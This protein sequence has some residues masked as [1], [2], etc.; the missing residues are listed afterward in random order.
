MRSNSHNPFAGGTVVAPQ[1]D[2]AEPPRPVPVRVVAWVDRYPPWQNA[3]G[4]WMLHYMLRHL[5]EVGHEVDVVTN[6]PAEFGGDLPHM[7]EGVRVWPHADRDRRTRILDRGDVLVG[8]LLW[9][10]K[11]VHE[12]G[13]RQIPLVYLFHNTMTIGSWNLVPVNVTAIVWN[14]AWVRDT[15]LVGRPA[16]AG[17]PSVLCRPPLIPDDYAVP[18]GAFDREFVTL[19][20][21]N[22]DK[23]GLVMR[24][25]AEERQHTRFLGVEGA[26]GQQIR[27]RLSNVKHQPQTADIVRDAYARTR[28]LIVP[29][30]YESYGRAAVEA[31]AAGIPVIAHPTPGLIESCG[32]AAIYCDR[33]DIPAW[34]RALDMLDD[35]DTFDEWALRS[36]IR[37]DELGAVAKTD[38][39]E[40]EYLI[41]V[42]AGARSVKSLHMSDTSASDNVPASVPVEQAGVTDYA[43]REP[44][45]GGI[46]PSDSRPYTVEVESAEAGAD[47]D[48]P[49]L[50]GDV[51]GNA[52][53][54]AAWIKAGADDQAVYD[55]AL[56]AEYVESRRSGGV[57][58]TVESV[59]DPI[60]Y[61]QDESEG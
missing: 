55:R 56:A 27:P 39:A 30:N 33:A 26:Y 22:P 48:A 15:N 57:R 24:Q 5:V 19:V 18:G 17:V 12:A 34:H 23:G 52:T 50:V 49:D 28:V 13:S 31:M 37:A 54:A 1:I 16:W 60:L 7:V 14:A 20:N 44:V 61:P 42:A 6:I 32:D 36:L 35:R 10:N 51:P 11:I 8:H 47:A 9:T 25:L 2:Y 46:H 40:W 21:P 38:L 41:R 59:Y 29:S 58:T 3:G 53:E 43:E 45:M 4:E